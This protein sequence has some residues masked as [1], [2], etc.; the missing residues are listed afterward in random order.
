M[1]P[2]IIFTVDNRQMVADVAFCKE[3]NGLEV[4]FQSKI[5]KYGSLYDKV[6]PIIIN[7]RGHIYDKSIQMMQKYLPEINIHELMS[8]AAHA[9]V[10]MSFRSYAALTHKI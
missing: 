7:Y 6:I 3:E 1:K 10:S 9:I 4:Y 5:K 2:D 8:A